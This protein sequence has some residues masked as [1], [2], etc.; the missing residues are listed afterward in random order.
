MVTFVLKILGYITALNLAILPILSIL[1]VLYLFTFIFIY[2]AL[3]IL[4]IGAL[5]ILGSYTYRENKY[6]LSIT[7]KRWFDFRKYW[8][9]IRKFAKLTTE[10]RQ[11]YRQEGIIMIIIGFTLLVA[12]IIVNFYTPLIIFDVRSPSKT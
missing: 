7:A 3:F 12:T 8:F 5:Q 11:R 6:H 4:I 10:E 9:D 2:E 1:K